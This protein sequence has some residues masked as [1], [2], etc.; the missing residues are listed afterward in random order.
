[1]GSTNCSALKDAVLEL[2]P[3]IRQWVVDFASTMPFCQDDLDDIALA[4]GEASTNAYKY[5]NSGA[6]CTI[7]I[8]LEGRND[9]L[10]T[11][12]SDSGCGFDPSAVCPPGDGELCEGGRGILFMRAAMD[13][14]RI[15]C[16]SLGT[17]VEMIKFF[18]GRPVA[19]SPL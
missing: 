7:K 19:N 1:M 16:C 17:Q 13:D 2:I 5:G 9:S 10:Y 12:I 15:S 14:V 4:V 3:L 18:S 8:R 6:G 11:R